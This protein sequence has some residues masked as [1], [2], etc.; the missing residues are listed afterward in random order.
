M[1]GA[2]VVVQGLGLTEW[3]SCLTASLVQE[4]M[5]EESCQWLSTVEVQ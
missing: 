1:L 2:N 4:R 3:T 5:G